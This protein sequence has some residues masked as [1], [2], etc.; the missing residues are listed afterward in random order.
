ML[1]DDTDCM[2]SDEDTTTIPVDEGVGNAGRVD[3]D[4]DEGVEGDVGADGHSGEGHASHSGEGVGDGRNVATVE[5]GDY[6]D[7]SVEEYDSDQLQSP[8]GSDDDRE[9]LSRRKNNVRRTMLVPQLRPSFFNS[10]LSSDLLS[11]ASSLD[12]SSTFLWHHG[13]Y[14]SFV[15]WGGEYEASGWVK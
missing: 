9:L 12:R 15:I 10:F 3:G 11:P 2:D 13:L 5:G 6:S 14:T 8:H 4:E 7:D 1:S